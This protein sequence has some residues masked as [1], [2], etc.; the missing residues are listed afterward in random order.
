MHDVT[1]LEVNARVLK[2][3]KD[4][5]NS[6]LLTRIAGRDMIAIEAKYHK[7]CMTNLNNRHRAFLRKMATSQSNNEGQLNEARAFVELVSFMESCC[8]DD[9]KYIFT[10]SELH[11]LCENRLIDFGIEK[12]G[13]KDRFL[14]NFC[15]ELQEQSDGK[16]TL[17]VFKEGMTCLLRDEVEKQDYESEHVAG[18]LE[19]DLAENEVVS[20]SSYHGSSANLHI[21]HPVICGLLPLFEENL[22]P[23]R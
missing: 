18:I 14:K 1:T 16:S 10:L 7:R 3:A 21:P 8:M 13:F 19:I 15:G 12:T 11:K 6:S 20:W 4:L 9:G 23:W 2:I 17:L 5:N 22:P